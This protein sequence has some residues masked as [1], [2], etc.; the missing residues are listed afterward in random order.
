[1]KEKE[2]LQA[3]RRGLGRVKQE[4][5]KLN[6][7]QTFAFG[8]QTRESDAASPA[9][10]QCGSIMMAMNAISMDCLNLRPEVS[11]RMASY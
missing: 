10:R 8:Q 3:R 11:R 4:R 1:M 5:Q 7:A 2:Y 6:R 9:A